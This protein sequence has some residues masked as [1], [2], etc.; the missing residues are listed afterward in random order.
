MLCSKH[1]SGIFILIV[2]GLKKH[3]GTNKDFFDLC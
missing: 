2:A 3:L 1:F